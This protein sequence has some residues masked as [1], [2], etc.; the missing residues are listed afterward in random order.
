MYLRQGQQE[1]M[2][3]EE[4]DR[5]VLEEHLHQEQNHCLRGKSRQLNFVTAEAGKPSF[6]R[7]LHDWNALIEN[8]TFKQTS[9]S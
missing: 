7:V 6:Q 1:V 2:C 3:L 9:R 4:Q 5:K 8:L